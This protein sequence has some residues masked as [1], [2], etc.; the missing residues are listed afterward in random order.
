MAKKKK[1][2]K[3]YKNK[4]LI[5]AVSAAMI[6]LFCIFIELT[7]QST[8]PEHMVSVTPAPFP[9][10]NRITVDAPNIQN[11]L[12]TKNKNSRSGYPLKKIHGIVIHYTA[13]PNTDA[14]ANRNY[15]E[16]RKN[17]ADSIQNKVSSHYIIGLSGNI[18][19]C[20]PDTEIAYASNKR[21][22]DTLSI[23]CCH[24]DSTGKF[25]SETYQALIHLTAYLADKYEIPIREII[26]HY[27]VTGKNC[28]KYYVQHEKAWKKL[29]N[30][31]CAYLK[32]HE[33]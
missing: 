9:D 22:K 20:I 1:R 27:D 2:T 33:S 14:K 7:K 29:K 26:R 28:P 32:K 3:G 19:R 24:P 17:M 8:S 15:F 16:S 10:Y 18:I 31:I 21:N 30:D 12:L 23:E 5:I 13:N 6:L 4:T 25:S 11:M